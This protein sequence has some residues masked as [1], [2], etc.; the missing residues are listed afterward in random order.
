VKED[1]IV[2]GALKDLILCTLDVG[3]E[4]GKAEANDLGMKSTP[5]FVLLNAT[6][7]PLDGW[8]GYRGPESWATH[9]QSALS[10]LTTIA[11]K[12][13]RFDERPNFQ[14]AMTLGNMAYG[15]G[16]YADAVKYYRSARDLDPQTAKLHDVPIRIFRCTYFGVGEGVFGPQEVM[17]EANALT[18]AEDPD[19]DYVF[20]VA[21]RMVEGARHINMEQLA[22]PYLERAMSLSEDQSDPG[23]LE[24]R[25]RVM[26][27]HAL[28]VEKD[29]DK[30]VKL[31]K[32]YMPEEWRTDA[33][34]LNGFAWWCF[35]NRINLEEAEKLAGKG[36]KL[37]EDNTKKANIMDTQAEIANAL[38][39]SQAAV[40]LIEKACKLDPESSY[41]QKQ[42]TRFQ[43][44]A[45]G[46]K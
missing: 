41:L 9:L 17:A 39:D 24:G 33:G 6:G 45:A 16:K 7:E 4:N 1:S 26:P 28:I 12:R 21:M 35:E 30:A 31:K 46:S 22:V 2:K 38:G 19:L 27:M 25:H 13:E 34:Q 36:V 23:V 44:L 32:R 43:D 5:G 10:D 8:V 11:Q 14:D 40:D 20:E 15:G 3:S 42:L 37:A 29:A 18:L